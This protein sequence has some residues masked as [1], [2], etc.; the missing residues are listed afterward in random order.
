MLMLKG[1]RPSHACVYTQNGESALLGLKGKRGAAPLLVGY[2]QCFSKSHYGNSR[3]DMKK[4]ITCCILSITFFAVK[5][6]MYEISL[7]G[8]VS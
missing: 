8:W 4:S 1:H 2:V 7:T 3:H 5:S 6:L